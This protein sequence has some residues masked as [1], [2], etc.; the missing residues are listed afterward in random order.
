MIGL[1]T[2]TVAADINADPVTITCLGLEV[3]VTFGRDSAD[4]QPTSATASLS[5]A[6]D[7]TDDALP[8]ELDIGAVLRV[9]TSVAGEL[10]TRFV[11]RVTDI[12]VGWTES[13]DETPNTV[14]CSVMA[15]SPLSELG[16]RVVGDEPWPQELDGARSCSDHVA[17][18]DHARPDVLR[19]GHRGPVGP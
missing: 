18:R 6:L 4:G 15:A 13:G 1:H 8:A 19:P 16:R 5:I 3:S 17:S 11:G 12:D 7:T 9:F 2:V 10:S 14:E